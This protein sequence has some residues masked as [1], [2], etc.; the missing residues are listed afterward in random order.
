MSVT[1]MTKRL[2]VAACGLA[3]IV[4]CGSS[5]HGSSNPAAAAPTTQ[6]C[7]V[8]KWEVT[9]QSVSFQTSDGTTVQLTGDQGEIL[10]LTANGGYSE[11]VNNAKPD[12]GSDGVNQY[13]DTSSGTLTG[14]YTAS[15]GALTVT[16]DK[17][18]AVTSVLSENGTAIYTQPPPSG[19]LAVS[20]TCRRGVSL[21]T[22]ATSPGGNSIN[23]TTFVSVK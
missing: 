4:G 22:S 10:T 15:G 14:H 12:V 17:P 11:D 7:V 2:L 13:A 21:T 19:P 6:S 3:L 1:S 16:E 5:S 9:N 8:G 23:T 20:Y 18:A